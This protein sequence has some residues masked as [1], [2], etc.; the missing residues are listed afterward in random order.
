[1]KIYDL[2]G[3]KFGRLLVLSKH[4]ERNKHNQVQWNCVCDCG[5]ELPVRTNAL[6]Q[7]HKQSCG[8]LVK[9]TSA[10]TNLIHGMRNTPLY[11]VFDSMKKRCYNKDHENYKY[12]GGR[13]IT[14]CD[15]W[16][17]SAKSFFDWAFENGYKEGLQIDRID[18]NKGYSPDNCR[19]I[20]RL[21]NGLTKRAIGVS[22][23]LGLTL[24]PDGAYQSV[25]GLKGKHYSLG[26]GRD[27]EALSLKRQDFVKKFIDKFGKLLDEEITSE[28]CEAFVKEW[29]AAN[30]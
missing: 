22:G 23:V 1:M 9:E 10:K 21:C 18:V 11:I 4:P 25:V 14:I 2:V 12:Y 20:N 28:M 24:K 15:E 30:K 3:Q 29:K 8:C 19:F 26:Y 27:T 5:T 17:N 16:L 7:G 6:V 13:G